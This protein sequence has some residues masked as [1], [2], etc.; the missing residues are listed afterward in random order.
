MNLRLWAVAA[1]LAVGSAVPARAQGRGDRDDAN[2]R[3]D[4]AHI[5]TS[6]SVER[7]NPISPLIARRREIG[8]PDSLIGKLGAILSQLDAVNAKSLH[9]VD[10][11]AAN[12]EGPPDAAPDPS[13]ERRPRGTVSLDLL[14]G[15]IAKNNDTAGQKALNLLHG[16]AAS[17]ALKIVNDQRN[18]LQQLLMDSG[19]GRR[20]R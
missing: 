3:A 15:Q 16:D 9:Q 12:R 18:K 20:G 11:L 13:E 7:L 4:K 17:R 6:D 5:V 2:S 10:S 14:I 8:I 1:T 19:F